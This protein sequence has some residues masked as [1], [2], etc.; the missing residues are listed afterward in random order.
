MIIN[1]CNLNSEYLKS[2]IK[3]FKEFYKKYKEEIMSTQFSSV[4]EHVFAVIT[5]PPINKKNK[6]KENNKED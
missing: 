5:L 1:I 6:E 4:P 3:S 2:G